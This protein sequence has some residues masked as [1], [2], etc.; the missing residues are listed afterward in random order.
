MEVGE[1]GLGLL[2]GFEGL[3]G[4]AAGGKGIRLLDEA[5]NGEVFFIRIL[6]RTG[7]GGQKTEQ[8][9]DGQK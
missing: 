9:H 3:L 5:I 6:L 8:Q 2:V 1:A 7:R 4:L